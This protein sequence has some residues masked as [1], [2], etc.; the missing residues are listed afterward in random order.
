MRK[1]LPFVALLGLLAAPSR[2]AEQDQVDQAAAIMRRFLALPE[3][4]IPR[5]VMR[6]AQGFAILTILKGGFV[7]SGRAGE[8]VVVSR[9][10]TGWS[11]PSFVVVGGVGFGAQ[12][13]GQVTECVLVL[14]TP[15]AVRAFSR[16]GNVQLG[17]SLS[18]AAG[19]L[20]RTAS[21]DVMPAAAV[22]S[23]SRSQGLFAGASLEGT[24]LGTNPAANSRYYGRRLRA[25][26]IL[27][28]RAV[29][30]RGADVLLRL[31]SSY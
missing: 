6:D 17:G 13:G 19:P 29:P 12:I 15:E 8:G 20:G 25:E 26:E 10:E 7:F 14:N 11:G 3:K 5:S 2:A 9:T 31:L 1:L 27:S 16:R 23:Y 4:G 30:P 28:G 18:V 21:A 22:Y 24:V